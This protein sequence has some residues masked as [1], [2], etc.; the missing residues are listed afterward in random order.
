MYRNGNV[1]PAVSHF[2]LVEIKLFDLLVGNAYVAISKRCRSACLLKKNS[3]A[4][5]GK[6]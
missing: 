1:V 6:A 3:V 2:A 5:G 4:L